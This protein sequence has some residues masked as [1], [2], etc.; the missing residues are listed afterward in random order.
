MKDPDKIV[1]VE[2]IT[3][4]VAGRGTLGL[5]RGIRMVTEAMENSGILPNE[6]PRLQRRLA[7]FN[8]CIC[9]AG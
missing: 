5:M 4:L 3:C 8:L 7:T 1:E 2:G 6:E 9:S